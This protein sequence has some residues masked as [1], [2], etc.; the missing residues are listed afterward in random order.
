MAALAFRPPFA[1]WSTN[2]PGFG[3]P[4]RLSGDSAGVAKQVFT[5]G[6]PTAAR[7]VRLDSRLVQVLI[8]LPDREFWLGC[9]PGEGYGKGERDGKTVRSRWVGTER[10]DQ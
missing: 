10:E 4:L 8:Q 3:N 5:M 6:S 9:L 2:W 7:V 1:H